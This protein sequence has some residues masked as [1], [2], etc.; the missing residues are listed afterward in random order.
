MAEEVAEMKVIRTAAF[1][2]KKRL[3]KLFPASSRYHG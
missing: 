2:E 1:D 3:F